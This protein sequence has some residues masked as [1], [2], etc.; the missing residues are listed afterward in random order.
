MDFFGGMDPYVEIITYKGRRFKSKVKK[1]SSPDFNETFHVPVDSLDDR[2]IIKMMEKDFLSSDFI[3][4][5]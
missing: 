3:G 1:G 2:V 4:E 5:Q